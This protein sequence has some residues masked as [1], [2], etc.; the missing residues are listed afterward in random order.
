MYDTELHK[1]S[2]KKSMPREQPN[3]YKEM[4]IADSVFIEYVH[5]R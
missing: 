5:E 1:N 4:E 2:G 3:Q